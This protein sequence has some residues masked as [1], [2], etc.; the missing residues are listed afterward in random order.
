MVTPVIQLCLGLLRPRSTC[1][2]LAGLVVNGCAMVPAGRPSAGP[3]Q[4]APPV[5]EVAALRSGEHVFR[6][7]PG[8][9]TAAYEARE[10]WLN[11]PAPTKAIASTGDVEGELTLALGE[12]PSLTASRFRVDLRTLV[13]EVADTPLSDRLPA[14][15]FLAG[16]DNTTRSRLDVANHPF[17]EFTGTGVEGLPSAYVPG[18]TVR[19]RV[20]GDLTIRGTTRP[21]VFETEA[22]LQGSRLSGTAAADIRMTDFGVEPPRAATTQVQDQL[23]VRVQFVATTAV[24]D[25]AVASMAD[26]N[27]KLDAPLDTVTAVARD[28][29]PSDALGE[30]SRLGL[31]V[32]EDRVRLILSAPSP[33]AATVRAA[34]AAAGGE[35]EAEIDSPATG[36]P[37][38]YQVLLPVAAIEALADQP[39]V[40]YLRTPVR[41]EPAPGAAD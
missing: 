39:V 10:K 8:E 2:V 16:R 28:R 6:V 35:I 7:V 36:L 27:P 30:A 19:A 18:Q 20:A 12:Q 14:G 9:S 5:M 41:E 15:L 17:A 22:T 32:V 33:R 38:A 11:W 34:I 23:T 24:T 37:F 40:S 31:A 29:G 13:S 1:L 4:E 25:T 26:R 21:T 3:P